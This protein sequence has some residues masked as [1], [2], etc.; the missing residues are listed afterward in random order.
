M[1]LCGPELL[2]DGARGVTLAN[3]EGHMLFGVPGTPLAQ[4]ANSEQRLGGGSWP[5]HTFQIVFWDPLGFPARKGKEG[6]K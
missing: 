3:P 1:L 6:R 4:G 5:T 2:R